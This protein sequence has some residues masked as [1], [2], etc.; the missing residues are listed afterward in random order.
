[1]GK[2][3]FFSRCRPQGCDAVDIAL[4]ARR[5]FVGYPPWHKAPGGNFDLKNVAAGLYDIGCN[6]EE[7]ETAKTALKAS[8]WYH[9]AMTQNHNLAREVEVGSIACIPRPDRGCIYIGRVVSRFVLENAPSAWANDYIKLRKTQGLPIQPE[10]SHIGD[11]VQCWRV[12]NFAEVPFALVPRWATG[13]MMG[14]STFGRIHPIDDRDPV[15]AL[16]QLIESTA[17]KMPQ[18]TTDEAEILRRL[19]DHLSPTAFEYLCV[20]L[21]QLE[22]PD[23]MWMQVGGSGDGGVDGLGSDALGKTIATLQCKLRFAGSPT[24]YET[25][26]DARR[27]LRRHFATLDDGEKP[28]ASKQ[29]AWFGPDIAWLVKKH[30]NSLPIARSMRLR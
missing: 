3:A 17:R 12:D 26:I 9:R 1:M 10:A 6:E 14:R 20:E 19:R 18:P 16:G 27:K 22:Y 5:I 11:V 25:E 28:A 8:K 2:I 7:W 21:L 23:E 13:A 30:A 29:I 24:D 15:Q 4:Q